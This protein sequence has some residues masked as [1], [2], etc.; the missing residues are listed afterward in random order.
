MGWKLVRHAFAMVFGNFGHALR[1]SVGPFLMLAAMF[2]ALFFLAS[3]ALTI[4]QATATNPTEIST[5]FQSAQGTLI[6]VMLVFSF[7]YFFAFSWLAVLWHRFILLEEY[8]NWHP[9]LSGR[10]VL[11]YLGKT[12]LAFLI[13]FALLFFAM[14]LVTGV[15]TV[16][17]MILP[18]G[19][20]ALFMIV[21][22]LGVVVLGA[23]TWFRL[24]IVL[25]GT[26]IGQPMSFSEAWSKTN[27][28]SGAIFVAMLILA[29]MNIGV[30][31]VLM[32][33]LSVLGP[34]GIVSQFA[35]QWISILISASMLTTLYGH[36]IEGRDLV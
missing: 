36:V 5:E 2:V 3:D 35:I 15:T 1:A 11:Q 24:A 22:T 13:L 18:A 6:F 26:A 31:L 25:P 34:V 9:V 20:A 10:P 33:L 27:D 32:P 30:G 16:L 19:L 12:V 17:N 14:L 8:P 7:A 29:L 21:I 23:V 4:L 28:V